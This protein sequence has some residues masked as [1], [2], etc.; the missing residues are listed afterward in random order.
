MKI[1][2][3]ESSRGWGGQELR[4][5][6]EARGMMARGHEVWI[7]A[8]PESRIAQ[9][10]RRKGIPLVPVGLRRPWPLRDIVRLR[11]SIRDLAI[12]VVNTHSSWDSWVGGLAAR[13][14]RTRVRVVRTRHLSTRI[15]SSRLS[16]ILY[17]R[18][19]DHIVCTGEAIRQQMIRENGF[20]PARITSVVTGVDSST[21]RPVQD[22][23]SVRAALG[24]AP[25]TP[26]VGTLSTLRSWKGHLHLLEALALLRVT[27]DIRGLLVGDG[28]YEEVIRSRIKDLRLEAA[29]T[30][31]GHREDV[32]DL[33]LAMDVFAFPSTANEGV[34]QA[35]LQAMA[36]RRPVVASNLGGI[37]EVVRDGETG[38]L[39]PPRDAGAL[40]QGLARVLDDPV[41]A[42]ERTE[43]AAGLVRGAYTL[44][45]MLDKMEGVYHKV[46]ASARDA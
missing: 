21:L 41:G 42:A 25:G 27:R 34:P 30:M 7:A 9:A 10:T 19:A 23:G 16:R 35:V 2:H 3:T 11:A 31:A 14:A 37:P 18:V 44:E 12:D 4:I 1:L 45:V 28:P 24:V 22:A 15:G 39:V 20:P 36:L 38:L 33:L 40:A 17:T 32:A 29:V 5:L 46:C 8:P 43:K 26:L 6:S 13:L